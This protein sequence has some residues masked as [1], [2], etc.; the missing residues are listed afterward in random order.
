MLLNNT[1]AS[2]SFGLLTAAQSLPGLDV[3]TNIA[4]AVIPG[5]I[6]LAPNNVPGAGPYVFSLS[7]NTIFNG[8]GK[9]SPGAIYDFQPCSYNKTGHLC[10][11]TG[12]VTSGYGTGDALVLNEHLVLE[13]TV[14]NVDLHEFN[15]KQSLNSSNGQV[16]DTA[17]LTVYTPVRRDL[18]AF[19]VPY[20]DDQGW[21]IDCHLRAV[22]LGSGKVV[23]DWSSLDHVPLSE[24]YVLP[25]GSINGLTQRFAWD[26]FHLSSIDRLGSGDYIVSSRHTST[27]Y[28]VSSKDGSIMWRLGG[29]ASTFKLKG[30]K[31]SSQHDVRVVN[32]DG[33]IVTL[34][35]FDNAYNTFT[36]PQGDSSGKIIE[37]N[38]A[39]RTA[40]L[41]HQYDPPQAGFQ[42]GDGGSLMLLPKGNVFIGWGSTPFVT[43]HTADGR[44]V[45]S[46]HFGVIGSSASSYRA[47]KGPFTPTPA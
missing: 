7:G 43:E 42:S 32:D 27:I 40:R 18:S 8:A 47:F 9:L 36:P 14:Q 34:S 1:I 23:F 35:M 39:K 46:A 20:E 4:G 3:D 45:Y 10:L 22:D 26:Y 33:K 29:K 21:V 11:W 28:C 41:L 44:L 15:I 24:S 25:T 16:T 17:L 5:S 6:Y 31:F 12:A 13:Q 19:G 37:L 2:V 30:F 38:I